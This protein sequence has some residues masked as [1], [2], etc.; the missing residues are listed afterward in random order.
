M[1]FYRLDLWADLGT[2]W[3]TWR[4]LRVLVTYLP[5]GSALSRAR[6]GAEAHWGAGEYLL[7]NVVDRLQEAVWLLTDGK[8]SKPEPIDRPADVKAKSEKRRLVRD[9]LLDQAK[10]LGVKR[11]HGAR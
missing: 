8:G 4:R 3:L 9:R 11:G 1:R 7:A 10:R 2:D 6:D 5:R